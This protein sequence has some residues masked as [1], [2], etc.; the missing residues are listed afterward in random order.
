MGANR[1]VTNNRSL[2]L[3]YEIIPSYPIGGVHAD[4]LDIECTGKGIIPWTSSNGKQ[5]LIETLYCKDVEG[6][7]ISP[8]TL[9]TQ[10]S[11]YYRGF[12]IIT[13]CDSL[14]DELKLLHRDGVSH[15]SFP[16]VSSND[17]WNYQHSYVPI[18]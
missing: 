3:Q 1:N 17:L 12:T 13:D 2:L 10:Q 9:V 8:T 11:L 6:T 4:E 15:C 16:L 7:I 18:Q 14:S 5:H